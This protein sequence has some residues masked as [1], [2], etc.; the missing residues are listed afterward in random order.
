LTSSP[1]LSPDQILTEVRQ[2][3]F[4]CTWSYFLTGGR[5]C[6][7]YW[8]PYWSLHHL[9]F[10]SIVYSTLYWSRLYLTLWSLTALPS[11]GVFF[12]W[13]SGVFLNRH[14]I[15][16]FF[17]WPFGVYPL[18]GSSLLEPLESSLLDPL[19]DSSSLGSIW[20]W[21]TSHSVSVS[22]LCVQA[23]Y[24][25]V[26]PLSCLCLVSSS[27]RHF[28][29]RSP[30]CGPDT[31]FRIWRY[32]TAAIDIASLKGRN[33]FC[34]HKLWIAKQPCKSMYHMSGISSL[35]DKYDATPPPPNVAYVW[36]SFSFRTTWNVKA[37]MKHETGRIMKD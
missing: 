29:P 16:V 10:W 6:L 5:V 27:M 21:E 33:Q 28:I 15:G 36:R 23:V 34:W 20:V 14:S 3:H 2:L 24:F 26:C 11:I 32:I 22:C 18:L 9:T 12:T 25:S 1:S 31:A 17:T 30:R 13:P 4:L 37:M 35:P 7:P 19:L 8:T